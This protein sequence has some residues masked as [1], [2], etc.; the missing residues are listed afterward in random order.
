MQAE[1]YEVSSFSDELRECCSDGRSECG[2]GAKRLPLAVT[3]RDRTVT[4]MCRQLSDE[5]VDLVVRDGRLVLFGW[6]MK[7]R[8]RHFPCR[9]QTINTLLDL[10]LSFLNEKLHLKSS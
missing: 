5:R 2:H 7:P 9:I 3:V 4:Q 6:R 10:L 1:A 8:Q